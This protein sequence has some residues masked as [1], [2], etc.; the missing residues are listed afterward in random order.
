MEDGVPGR[1]PVPRH[2]D[3]CNQVVVELGVV[4]LASEVDG[5]AARVVGGVLE[6]PE[7]RSGGNGPQRDLDP[8]AG[9]KGEPAKD[10]HPEIDVLREV[11]VVRLTRVDRVL[12]DAHA[13][14][15][16]ALK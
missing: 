15:G 13:S 12:D 6:V 5:A 3:L 14:P 10:V 8:G 2:P 9:V 1:R 4:P 7:E 16:E 11:E